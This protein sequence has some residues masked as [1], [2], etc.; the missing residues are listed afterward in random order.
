MDIR[1]ISNNGQTA[2]P[3]TFETNAEEGLITVSLGQFEIAGGRLAGLTTLDA[4]E[5]TLSVNSRLTVD[6]LSLA[7]LTILLAQ[8][9]PPA[10]GNASGLM[11]LSTKG[12][13][14]KTLVSD[15]T[16]DLQLDVGGLEVADTSEG[17][18]ELKIDLRIDGPES[19]PYMLASFAR[20]GVP[21][22]L[23][24]ETGPL[25]GIIN[26]QPAMMELLINSPL[27]DVSYSGRFVQRPLPGLDGQL[28]ATTPDAAQLAA[29]LEQPLTGNPG[30]IEVKARFSGDGENN[31]IETFAVAAAGLNLSGAG[32]ISLGQD[33]GGTFSAS[34]TGGDLNLT[35]YL[36][37]ST[38]ENAGP[39]GAPGA[40][41]SGLDAWSGAVTYNA[42]SLTLERGNAAFAV[43]LAYHAA[44]EVVAPDPGRS[45]RWTTPSRRQPRRRNDQSGGERNA[46]RGRRA[47]LASQLTTC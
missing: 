13:D 35:P 12:A 18:T 38:G 42:S 19:T 4:R 15:L 41:P 27:G 24:L 6:R 21:V 7:D 25:P 3:L 45:A 1:E 16:A 32:E 10:L 30:S 20:N 40:M 14:L 31:R 17:I 47:Q 8:E 33:G 2:G 29:W 26:R 34:V 5:D 46:N 44:L 22:Y 43:E 9:Q 39:G 28:V 37:R 11:N 36:P 23:D